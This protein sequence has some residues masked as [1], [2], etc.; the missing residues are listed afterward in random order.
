M[1]QTNAV[2]LAAMPSPPLPAKDLNLLGK[3]KRSKPALEE[4][5][6]PV[7]EMPAYNLTTQRYLSERID[8]DELADQAIPPPPLP[9]DDHALSLVPPPKDHI[10][11]PHPVRSSS[12]EHHCITNGHIFYPCY[13]N[14]VPYETGFNNL[15]VRPYLRTPIGVKQHVHIPVLCETCDKDVKGE[16]WKCSMPN[17]SVGVCKKCAEDME[18]EWIER[19]TRSSPH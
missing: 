4:L 15:E 8:T 5:Q 9:K 2:K 7:Q 10:R 13:L 19:V 17:C 18:H 12:K 6:V 14:T 1:Y 16:L 11:S 3:G